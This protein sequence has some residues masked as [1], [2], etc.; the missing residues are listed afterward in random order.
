MPHSTVA[1]YT[2]WKKNCASCWPEKLSLESKSWL[3][4]N[5]QTLLD[6]DHL[7][8]K[9]CA[10]YGAAKFGEFMLSEPVNLEEYDVSILEGSYPANALHPFPSSPALQNIMLAAEGIVNSLDSSISIRICTD[11]HHSSVLSLTTKPC[12]FIQMNTSVI[13]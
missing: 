9:I 3:L 1:T 4:C 10:V 12:Y 13:G 7:S 6:P 5:F 2:E 8:T 11:C